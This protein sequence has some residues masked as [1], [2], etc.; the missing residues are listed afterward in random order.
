MPESLAKL[1]A[2]ELACIR[3]QPVVTID[4][5]QWAETRLH[6]TLDQWQKDV[7]TQDSQRLMLCCPR[8]AGKSTV[9]GA[10]AAS[11]MVRHANTRVVVISPTARQSGLLASKISETLAGED[12]ISESVTRLVLANGSSLD[13]LPGDQPKNIRGATADLL[14]ID[15]ASRVKPE[16]MAAALPMVIATNGRVVLLSTPAG[17]SGSFYEFWTE[18]DDWTKVFV[19]AEMVGHYTQ[20]ALEAMKKKLG[21]RAW[22]QEFCGEFLEAPGALFDNDEIEAL[23]DRSDEWSGSLVPANTPFV[24]LF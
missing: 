12:V 8:Q 22:R 23:F 1:L 4:P 10:L 2:D 11:Q 16:L 3:S 7:L 21:D 24:R 14:I 9:V 13:S 5:V 18:D 6:L 15:E 20:D 17:S 19:T